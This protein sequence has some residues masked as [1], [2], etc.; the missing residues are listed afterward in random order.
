MHVRFHK[1]TRSPAAASMRRTSSLSASLPS[2]S[3]WMYS[4]ARSNTPLFPFPGLPFPRPPLPLGR[5]RVGIPVPGGAPAGARRVVSCAYP[6]RMAL[7]RF[8]SD[9]MWFMRF[10]GLDR[11][12][13]DFAP[14]PFPFTLVVGLGVVVPEEEW[15]VWGKEREEGMMGVS[16]EEAVDEVGE[17][18]FLGGEPL[19]WWAYPPMDE[20]EDGRVIC[21]P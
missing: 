18:D 9:M 1:S 17:A 19:M 12:D 11:R 13:L 4:T 5:P 10:C 15:V 20:D 16:W 14:F 6:S 21:V 7:R 8:C 2:S 3:Q